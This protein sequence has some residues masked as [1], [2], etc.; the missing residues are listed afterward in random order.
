MVVN[1]K[2]ILVI[3]IVFGGLIIASPAMLAISEI[4]R[5]KFTLLDNAGVLIESKGV[6]V[7]VDPINIPSSYS[8]SP[9]DV[10]L[11]T[12]DHG[13]HYDYFSINRIRKDTTIFVFPEGMT[14]AL[15]TFNGTAVNPG[16]QITYEHI[17]ITTFYMYTFPF[18]EIPASHPKAANWTSYIID[19]DGFSFFHAGDS[20]NIP[21][22][23]Q[24]TGLIDVALLPL[25]PGCQTMADMEIVD[26]INVIQ[27]SY[28]FPIHYTPPANDDFYDTYG[29]LFQASYVNLDYFS[30]YRF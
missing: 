12:H 17:T 5:I 30:S 18:G 6:R 2:F 14:T 20:K 15:N 10:V 27:P 28:V 13:D 3:G 16:D 11:V 22:Y 25:G 8:N 21:E 29:V 7:Y 19:V 26:V 23:A 9:A 1:K 24:L 4:T